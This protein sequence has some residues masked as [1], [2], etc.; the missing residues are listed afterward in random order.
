MDIEYYEC[1]C[2]YHKKGYIL[3]VICDEWINKGNKRDDGNISIKTMAKQIEA[4]K[5]EKNKINENI[6][7]TF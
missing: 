6:N 4:E 5:T 2:I 7:I 3:C 1:D